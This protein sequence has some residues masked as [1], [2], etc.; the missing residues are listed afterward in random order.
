MHPNQHSDRDD[1]K[2]VGIGGGKPDSDLPIYD[3][4]ETV[5]WQNIGQLRELGAKVRTYLP[6]SFIHKNLP[7][8]HRPACRVRRSRF[9]C[10]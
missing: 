2:E 7:S 9:A 8:G 3:P 6:G 4:D 10:Y 5:K 1:K